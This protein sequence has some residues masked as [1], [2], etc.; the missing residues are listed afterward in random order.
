MVQELEIAKACGLRVLLI[1]AAAYIG[2]IVGAVI[3]GLNLD[4][5]WHEVNP[6]GLLATIG[7]AAVTPVAN[8]ILLL[9]TGYS[10]AC[11]SFRWPLWSHLFVVLMFAGVAYVLRSAWR[12]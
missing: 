9:A 6:Y 5:S 7:L 1:I 11:V 8:L 10:I 12:V 4:L 3:Y 2:S